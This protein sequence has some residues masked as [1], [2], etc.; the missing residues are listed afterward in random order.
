MVAMGHQDASKC[1]DADELWHL[2]G[3]ENTQVARPPG[4]PA[5]PV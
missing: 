3:I 5:S 4:R 1:I 2:C